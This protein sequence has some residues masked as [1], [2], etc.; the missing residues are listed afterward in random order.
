L[1]LSQF[2]LTRK[3]SEMCHYVL[4]LVVGWSRLWVATY[5]GLG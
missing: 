2:G 5:C 3:L 4:M 1:A